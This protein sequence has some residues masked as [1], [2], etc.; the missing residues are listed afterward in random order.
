[1]WYDTAI[2][3]TTLILSNNISNQWVE[4]LWVRDRNFSQG[5]S[6]AVSRRGRG[7]LKKQV[8]LIRH[9]LGVSGATTK[10]H[11]MEWF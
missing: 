3:S 7:W 11:I 2:L 8:H 6:I 4:H 1:M 5:G 9:H 10:G